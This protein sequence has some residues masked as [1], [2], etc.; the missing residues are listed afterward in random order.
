MAGGDFV[1][2]VCPI[3]GTLL[4]VLMLLSPFPAV[5]KMRKRKSIGELNPLPMVLT[6]LNCVGW[7]AYG[8][9]SGN[10][11]VPPGNIVGIV[12]GLYF[13]GEVLIVSDRQHQDVIIG[14]LSVGGLYFSFLG[15][16][17]AFELTHLQALDMWSFQCIA[18]LLAYYII[19]LSTLYKVIKTKNA[20]SIYVPLS[21]STIVNGAMW[22]L[23][24]LF[25]VQDVTLWLPNSIGA[26]LGVLQ[27]FLRLIYGSHPPKDGLPTVATD[28]ENV[29]YNLELFKQKGGP[30]DEDDRQGLLSNGDAEVRVVASMSETGQPAT[31]SEIKLSA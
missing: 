4:S 22:A 8:C 2:V 24:G 15:C 18:I 23:Y 13:T 14:L 27:V 31:L 11:W 21:I 3:L 16:I 19:P 17:T 7:V 10:P 26:V 9:V 12:G 20:S 28:Q 25:G 1:L 6:V 29:Q 5:L 30:G